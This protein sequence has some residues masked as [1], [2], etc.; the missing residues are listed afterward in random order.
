M[1]SKRMYVDHLSRVDLFEDFSRK[2]LEK[3][4]AA[5]EHVA[6]R[7]GK[8]LFVEDAEGN[9]AFVVLSG[10]V[11]V[12]RNGKTVTTLGPGAIIGELALLDRGPRTAGATCVTD[13]EVLV[14]SRS[15]FR[16]LVD[17]LPALSHKLLASLAGRLRDLDKRSY[18]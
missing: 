8:T 6:L 17:Q 12:V 11:R 18:G 7:A 14:L 2:D 16:G 1:P 13:S 10:S 15:S 5:G 4:A 9:E 3:V